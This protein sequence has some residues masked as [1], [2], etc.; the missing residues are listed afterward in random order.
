MTDR[1]TDGRPA[2]NCKKL[3]KHSIVV[4]N[5]RRTVGEGWGYWLIFVNMFSQ[6]RSPFSMIASPYAIFFLNIK[7]NCRFH[8]AAY[9]LIFLNIQTTSRF[10]LAAYWLFFSQYS[11]LFVSHP[12]A[13]WLIFV[14]MF[15]QCRSPSSMIAFPYAIF[16]LNIKT[17]AI[18]LLQHTG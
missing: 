1:R 12:L 10:P 7:N 17:T 6:C 16:F 18:S 14:N 3:E 4:H 5:S 11:F 8:Y 13:Y 9:W 2:Y 15:S